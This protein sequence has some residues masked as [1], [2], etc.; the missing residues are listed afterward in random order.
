MFEIKKCPVKYCFYLPQEIV[1]QTRF[2]RAFDKDFTAVIQNGLFLETQSDSET[3]QRPGL[4]IQFRSFETRTSIP[5]KR[6][7]KAP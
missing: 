7:V 4:T 5:Y 2:K 6:R 1:I 3:L